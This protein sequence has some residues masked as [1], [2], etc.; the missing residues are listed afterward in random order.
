MKKLLARGRYL[1]L[2]ETVVMGIINVTPDSF[3]TGSRYQGIEDAVKKAVEMYEEGAKILDIGGE[4][5]RPGADPVEPQEEIRRVVP[6]IKELRKLIPDC[7]ISID[8]YHP[9]TA[10]AALDSGAD[11]VNDI[12]GLRNEKMMRLVYENNAGV[13]LM[14]MKGTPKTMQN[15]P[16]YEDVVSEVKELLKANAEKAVEM[17]IPSESI[18]IDPGIGFGKR[19]E[20]NLEILRKLDIFKKLGYSVLIGHS[21]K[22]FIGYI[23]DL[24]PEERLEGTLAVSAYCY[25]KNV[26]IIRV[27]DVREHIRLFKVLSALKD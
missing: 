22:S 27:H 23:L 11:I 13:I 18:V 5:S 17:G 8:T 7:F 6:V 19:F 4:S 16:Y 3:Y 25:L 15:E 10:K 24:P 14:H 21:R 2:S 9:E 12:T 1:D 20:D 26:E